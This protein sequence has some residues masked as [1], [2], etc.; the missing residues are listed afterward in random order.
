MNRSKDLKILVLALI[1]AFFVALIAKFLLTQS[2]TIKKENLFQETKKEE[3]LK[4]AVASSALVIG[5]ALDASRISW[6]EWPKKSVSADYILK[7][8][9]IKPLLGGVIRDE[10]EKGEPLKRSKIITAGEKGVLSAI[11]SPGKLAF[12]VPINKNSNISP[13]ISGG[14]YVDVVV[15]TP[16]ENNKGYTGRIVLENIR[17]IDVDGNFSRTNKPDNLPRF[18]TVE[19]DERQA[20]QLASALKEG[21]LSFIIRSIM[22][23]HS[24]K[25]EI[26]GATSPQENRVIHILR[27]ENK[28][29][30]SV[31]KWVK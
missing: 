23:K 6:Q 29:S 24:R 9:E 19:V 21:E 10:I 27:G 28:V 31:D 14:D 22:S 11:V 25:V 13:L 2:T 30:V 15:A 26:N 20:E 16:D 7:E 17:V 5:D 8:E 1:V 18:V 4:V 12:T 3:T